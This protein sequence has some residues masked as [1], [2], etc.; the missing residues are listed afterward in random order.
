[1]NDAKLRVEQEFNELSVK[2]TKLTDF[3]YSDKCTK[4]GISN[5]MRNVRLRQ[6]RCMTEYSDCL[7]EVLSIWD[8]PDAEI[9]FS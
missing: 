6:L 1:M 5:A 7:R 4:V 9:G 3:L 8:K 2:I